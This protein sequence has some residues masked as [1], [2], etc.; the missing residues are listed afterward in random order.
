MGNHSLLRGIG[1][2]RIA[3]H[4]NVW[5]CLFQVAHQVGVGPLREVKGLL[6]GSEDVPA[7]VYLRGW[8]SGKDTCLDIM[9]TN[10]ALQVGT[11]ERWAKDGAY[12]LDQ[13]MARSLRYYMET[14]GLMYNSLAGDKFR[15]WHPQD[16]QVIS[17]LAG[18]L[19]CATD[20]EYGMV[21]HHLGQRH[22]L[23]KL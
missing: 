10:N 20:D 4:N 8:T 17:C 6:E 13:V 12:A 7:N 11:L 15:G 19:A 1:G 2:E 9:A 5:D 18:Q 16:L 3:C 22:W 21:Q 23:L 14:E